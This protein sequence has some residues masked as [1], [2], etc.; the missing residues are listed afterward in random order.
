M[1]FI[2]KKCCLDVIK[3]IKKSFKKRLAKGIKIFLK[4]KKRQY[5]CKRNKYL[6][7]DKKQKI[8]EHSRNYYVTHKK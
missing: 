7:E 3:E 4:K 6:P 2:Y 1:F 5:F 8:A